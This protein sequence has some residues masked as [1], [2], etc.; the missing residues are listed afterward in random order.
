MAAQSLRPEAGARFHQFVLGALPV[1]AYVVN[2]EAPVWATLALSMTS[3]PPPIDSSS[4]TNLGVSG[5][6]DHSMSAIFCLQ[7]TVDFRIKPIGQIG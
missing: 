6:Q 7:A 1:F 5:R 4:Q 3:C 2:W